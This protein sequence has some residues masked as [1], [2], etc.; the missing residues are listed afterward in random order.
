MKRVLVGSLVL[1]VC[2][3]SIGYVH[4]LAK[5][6][7]KPYSG[8]TLNIA[9]YTFKDTDQY[10]KS[11]E[12]AASDLGVEL[13]IERFSF[14]GL[15]DKLITSFVAGIRVWDIILIDPK[16]IAEFAT[17][18]INT[19]LQDFIDNPKIA[20][21]SLL[22][23]DDF[24]RF[25][26]RC[27]T[28]NNKIQALPTVLSMVGMAYRTDLLNS[29]FEKK[30]F[31]ERYGYELKCPQ[32]YSEFYDIAE[33]FTRKRGEKLAGT[34]LEEDFYGATHSNKPGGFIWHD[35]LPYMIAFGADIHSPETMMPE[36]NS[37]ENIAA[38]EF[39]ISLSKFLPPGHQVMTSGEATTWF[40]EGRTA[41]D[42]EFLHRIAYIAGDS[43][44][45][46]IIGKFDYALMPSVK[47]Y[48]KGRHHVSL[49]SGGLIGIYSLSDHKEAAYKVIERSFSPEH[50]R[51][52]T[53]NEW[54]FIPIKTSIQ[55]DPILLDKLPYLKVAR[56][57]ST[58]KDVYM[59]VHPQLV[60]YPKLM[61]I[62]SR[63]LSKALAGEMSVEEAYNKA[64]EEMIEVMREAG[65]LK[66]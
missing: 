8:L 5:Q 48:P 15:R 50:Q 58:R 40:A 10:L 12:K 24:N 17:L 49:C 64:Q 41:L 46:K 60:V 35:Y 33:F 14:D 20:D 30:R 44:S 11:L 62:G 55:M 31:K 47:N 27:G 39:Y 18:G 28:Y 56:G 63:A 2:L 61:D 23:L 1:T 29:P 59:F 34:V 22:E 26:L 19:P 38:G 7:S 52:I 45:S 13:K 3:I 4:S 21:P 53:K 42:I 36:W 54:G 32:T 57:Y 65:Y 6:P 9:S 16:W 51:E 66:S 25:G 43:K 37:P